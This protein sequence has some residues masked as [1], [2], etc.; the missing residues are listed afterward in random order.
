LGYGPEEAKA[1]E[2]DAEEFQF[3][4]SEESR[5]RRVRN[6]APVEVASIA[7][8]QQLISVETILAVD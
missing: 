4:S 8:G 5:Y 6:V 7:V 2:G 1:A 3:D